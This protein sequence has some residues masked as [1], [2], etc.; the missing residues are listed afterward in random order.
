MLLPNEENFYNNLNME[1]ITDADHKHAEKV[2]KD[3][4]IKN[5]VEYHDLYVQSDALLLA[6]VFENFRGKCWSVF[7]KFDGFY[8]HALLVY[9]NLRNCES[10]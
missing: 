7:L 2:W 1:Y 6:D 9:R 3:F 5:L 8:E 10:S 4:K